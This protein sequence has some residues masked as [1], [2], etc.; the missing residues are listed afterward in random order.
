M[1][2]DRT[3]WLDEEGDLHVFVPGLMATGILVSICMF[4]WDGVR[5]FMPDVGARKRSARIRMQAAGRANDLTAVELGLAPRAM[6]IQRVRRAR[7]SALLLAGTA[8]VVAATVGFITL[9][10]YT[11][12]GG[13]FAGRG[14]TLSMGGSVALTSAALGIAALCAALYDP[15]SEPRWLARAGTRWPLGVLPNADEIDV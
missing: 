14:W 12:T 8:F 5:K 11:G 13:S 7:R 4:V 6:H 1:V 2:R 9:V 3:R 10:A 15:V